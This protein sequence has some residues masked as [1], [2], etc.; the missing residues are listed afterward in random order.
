MRQHPWLGRLLWNLMVWAVVLTIAFPLFW[1]VSTA[2]R[3]E[4]ELFQ[5]PPSLLPGTV[6]FEHFRRLVM[7]TPFPIYFRNSA[8]VALGTTL[9]VIIVGSLGAYSLSRFRYR[10]RGAIAKVVLLTYLMPSVVLFL[11]LYLIMAEL[12]LVNSLFSLVLAYMTFALPFALWLLRS[13][14]DAIPVE[15]ELAA[16]VDGASRMGAFFDV[17]LPQALPGIISTALFTFIL[18]WNEYLYALV[19][20]NRDTEKPLPPGVITMLTSSYNIEWA[21]LMAASVLMSLPLILSFAFMQKHLTRG[22]GAGAVKG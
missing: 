6:T 7:D 4:T 13:F 5:R 11:P 12:G 16:M 17:V 14:I 21:L 1:I 20:T 18:A 19:L 9:M 10:G 2:L 8:I 15:T 22:F 3:P